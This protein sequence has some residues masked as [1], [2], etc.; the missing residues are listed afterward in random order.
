MAREQTD[1]VGRSVGR[2][3]GWYEDNSVINE[4]KTLA[5]QGDTL[6]FD[7][8]VHCCYFF[9]LLRVRLSVCPSGTHAVA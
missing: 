4:A 6:T 5:S 8:F 1:S 2:S 3:V 7:F 9:P